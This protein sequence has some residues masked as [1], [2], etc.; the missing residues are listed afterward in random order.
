MKCIIAFVGMPG[1]GKTE[2]SR[3]LEK[4][5]FKRIRFGDVTE[6]EIRKRGLEVSE[7]NERI[8]R[9]ELRRTLGMD[10][11]AR[12]NKNRIERHLRSRNV[13]IDGMRSYEEH[14]L[15]KRIFKNRLI[16]VA[17]FA[18]IA[19]RFTRIGKRKTRPLSL[20]EIKS[21]SLIHISEPT[22]PY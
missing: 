7:L 12:L 19:L 1:V 4:Y 14:K 20:S 13:V 18:P 11:Y 22:R 8:I 16:T 15:L 3:I 10:A 6:E 5:E 9:E 17:L 21:L 2:A